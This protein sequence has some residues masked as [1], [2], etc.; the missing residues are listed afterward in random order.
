[1][2]TTILLHWQ[3]KTEIEPAL[4]LFPHAQA[5]AEL[6]MQAIMLKVTNTF[7]HLLLPSH[8]SLT[9]ELRVVFTRSGEHSKGFSS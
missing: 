6:E 3:K 7:A 1:M 9:E 4:R 5:V 2:Y 8:P